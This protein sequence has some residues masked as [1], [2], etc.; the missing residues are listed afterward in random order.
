MRQA[1]LR[2][3]D[4]GMRQKHETDDESNEEADGGMKKKILV[5]GS[6][7]SVGM[8]LVVK[9][10]EAAHM[11]QSTCNSLLLSLSL[12]LIRHKQLNL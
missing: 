4:R 6:H 7:Q 8:W 5:S 3:G 1:G 9:S 12:P 10:T 2:D 11:R